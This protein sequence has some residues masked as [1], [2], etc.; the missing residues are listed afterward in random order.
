MH[1][2]ISDEDKCSLLRHELGHICDPDLKNSAMS[3]SKIKKEEFANEFSFYIKNPGIIFKLKHFIMKKWKLLLGI[4]ALIGCVSGLF[5]MI[6][7]WI[8]K[9][10]KSIT[11]DISTSEIADNTY[12]VTS[13]GKKYHRKFCIIIKHRTNLTECTINE[14]VDG[15]Y[16][17]CQICNPQEE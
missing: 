12:F 2:D 5:F 13:S 15:G 14:A 1:T 11:G 10:T 3:H 7:S 9:P 6:N 8:I 17:P 16:K 4:I